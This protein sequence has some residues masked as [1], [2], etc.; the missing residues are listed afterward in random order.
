MRF[1]DIDLDRPDFQTLRAAQ[2]LVDDN[3]PI[4]FPGEAGIVLVMRWSSANRQAMMAR[5]GTSGKAVLALYVAEDFD[6]T[7]SAGYGIPVQMADVTKNRAYHTLVQLCDSPLIAMPTED[8][9]EEAAIA[10]PEVEYAFW[11]LR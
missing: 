5:A 8:T 9:R 3:Q 2:E 7:A 11:P 1:L 10:H 6:L 4:L